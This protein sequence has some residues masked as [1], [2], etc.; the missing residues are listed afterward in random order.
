MNLKLS[1]SRTSSAEVDVEA[2]ADGDLLRELLAEPAAVVE[3]RQDVV[4]GQVLELLLS[5]L[6]LGDV[7]EGHDGALAG[8]GCVRA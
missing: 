8:I 5:P 1:M 7:L 4:V 6:S 3:A 2:L